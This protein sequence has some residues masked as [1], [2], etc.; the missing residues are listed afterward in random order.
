MKPPISKNGSTDT[1]LPPVAATSEDSTSRLLSSTKSIAAWRVCPLR[2]IEEDPPT[3]ADRLLMF[4]KTTTEVSTACP[5]LIASPASVKTLSENPQS[6]M[7]I[8]AA[9]VQRGMVK[10]MIS[11]C[12]RDPKNSS[13]ASAART[14]PES[15]ASV[16]LF[17]D[18]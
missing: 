5:T 1:R 8:A 11:V 10:L 15:A 17:S 7:A 3:S 16:T 12:R 2:S 13:T 4:S 6:F 18:S 14:A 9:S